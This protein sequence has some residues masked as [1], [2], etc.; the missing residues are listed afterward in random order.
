M[1][2]DDEILTSMFFP[3]LHDAMLHVLE[4]HKND[5]I[6]DLQVTLVGC[7]SDF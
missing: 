1:F 5:G 6:G 3:S 4:K 7:T 2:F